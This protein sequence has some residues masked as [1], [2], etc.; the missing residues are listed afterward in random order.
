MFFSG[1]LEG[2]FSFHPFDSGLRGTVSGQT[3]P[4][5][6]H[7]KWHKVVSTPLTPGSRG[8]V[9]GLA[10]GTGHMKWCRIF[11]SRVGVPSSTVK[12]EEPTEEVPPPQP[13]S[14]NKTSPRTT[15]VSYPG[16]RGATVVLFWRWALSDTRA[17]SK[18]VDMGPWGRSPRRGNGS[19]PG[20]PGESPG[21][22]DVCGRASPTHPVPVTCPVL[23]TG[24][25]STLGAHGVVCDSSWAPPTSSNRRTVFVCLG[26]FQCKRGV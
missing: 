12:T 11:G 14:M 2:R 21:P 6:G 23:G 1:R 3:P 17:A 18:E 4:G 5:T 19:R 8:T 9:S 7:V 13:R 26:N 10:P 22:R 24:Y 15:R 16:A 25:Q 20:G